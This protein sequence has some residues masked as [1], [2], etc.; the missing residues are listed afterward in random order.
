MPPVPEAEQIELDDGLISQTFLNYHDRCDRAAYLYRRWSGGAPAHALNRGT[1][2]HIFAERALRHLIAEE[3]QSLPPEMAKEM[4]LEVLRDNPTLAVPAKERDVLRELAWN[5]A[6]GTSFWPEF[7]VGVEEQMTLQVGKWTIRCRIDLVEAPPRVCEVTDWKTAW[8]QDTSVEFTTNGQ[9]A[10]G[11]EGWPKW[12]GNFQTQ[13]YALALAEGVNGDGLPL[14]HDF[15]T[16]KMKLVYPRWPRPDG[17]ATKECT[18]TRA[19]LLDFKDDLE[20]QL[21]RV[22]ESLRTRE[23]QATPG[24]HCSECPAPRACPLP[25]HLRGDSQLPI[26]APL[27]DAVELAR[28]HFFTSNDTRDVMRRLKAWAK[29]NGPIPLGDDTDMEYAFSDEFR[30]EIPDKERLRLAVEGAANYGEEFNWT[31]FVRERSSTKFSKRKVAPKPKE[32]K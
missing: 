13:V 6:T 1:L 10:I 5:W 29:V 12:G 23:W 28:W 19:Q 22:E 24:S 9:V 4:M 11:T 8:A 17:L 7:I 20:V 31:H 14:A 16:F 18:I 2:F 21:D 3:E 27:G 15:D 26:D 25:R 32:S 30:E